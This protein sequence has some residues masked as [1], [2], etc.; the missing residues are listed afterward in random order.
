MD[1]HRVFGQGAD[2]SDIILV[3]VQE[4]M[5][6]LLINEF[7]DLHLVVAL[8]RFAPHGVL[9]HLGQ[10][11]LSG[12]AVDAVVIQVDAFLSRVVVDV[13]GLAFLDGTPC[14]PPAGLFFDFEPSSHKLGEETLA[15]LGKMAHLVDFLHHIALLHHL[16]Q[17]ECALGAGQGP[18]LGRVRTTPGLSMEREVQL[19]LDT[20]LTQGEGEFIPRAI[21]QDGMVQAW[22]RQ[23]STL[24]Q[25]KVRMEV[26]CVR[27]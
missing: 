26:N 20:G 3:A 21:G 7:S 8:A 13:L 12:I 1:F 27:G 25:T 19:L 9:H 22:G 14:R 16:L 4:L 10:G 5:E 24:G 17:F 23:H 15:T 2:V 11:A 6:G 18:L